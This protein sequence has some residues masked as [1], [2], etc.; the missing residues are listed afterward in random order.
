MIPAATEGVIHKGNA[1]NIKA[2]LIVEGGNG[3]VTADADQ[4]LRKNGVSVIPDFYANS[5]GVIVSYFE[6][7]QNIQHMCWTL[8]EVQQKLFDKINIAT[9]KVWEA[10]ERYDVNGAGCY[11]NQWLATA[12]GQA[13]E[14]IT[15]AGLYCYCA[16][17]LYCSQ[18]FL[19]L[20]M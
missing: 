18:P 5:G 2:S 14:A 12:I 16:G 19:N 4:I 13:L 6:W 20:L 15:Q 11:I 17:V 10:H 1:A 3:P 8:E 7:V 9:D